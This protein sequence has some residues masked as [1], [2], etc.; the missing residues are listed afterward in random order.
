MELGDQSILTHLAASGLMDHANQGGLAP[1]VTLIRDLYY[2]VF[3]RTRV[4]YAAFETKHSLLFLIADSS[5][6]NAS[7]FSQLDSF[8]EFSKVNRS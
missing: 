1:F 7:I 5:D 6:Q 3:G 8:R 2:G 4:L